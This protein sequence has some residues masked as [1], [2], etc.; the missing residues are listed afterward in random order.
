MKY[1]ISYLCAAAVFLGIYYILFA[2]A[3]IASL[4]TDG[5]STYFILIAL[6]GISGFMGPILLYYKH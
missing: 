5:S 4:L 6:A 3:A 1:L 2:I